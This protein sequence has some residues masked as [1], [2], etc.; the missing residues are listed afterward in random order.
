MELTRDQLLEIR[1]TLKARVLDGLAREGTEIACLPTYLPLPDGPQR[2][3]ALVMDAGGTNMR[4]SV[5]TLADGGNRVEAGPLGD[6][7]PTGRDG[8]PVAGDRFFEA[9]A[10][11]F[12]Q[13]GPKG[14]CPLGYCFSYPA[15][16][17]ASRDARLI[18]WT[19]GVDV[20]GVEGTLVGSR[21][22]KAL[23]KLSIPTNGVTVLNDTVASLLG[24]VLFERKPEFADRFIGLI[25]GTGTNMAGVFSARA[26]TKVKEWSGNMLVNLESGNFHPPHLQAFDDDY[27]RESDNPGRQRFEKAV[28]GYYLPYLFDRLSPG[29]IDPARGSAQLVEL[30][31]QGKGE[32]ARLAG[33]LLGRSAD[34]VAAGLAALCEIYTPGPTAIL[35]EGSLLWGDPQFATRMEE[36]V[37][38][39]IS[40]GRSAQLVKQRENVNLFGAASAAL[41]PA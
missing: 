7:V 8:K 2:G 9:Q 11:L 37:N 25:V 26:L 36:R 29:T 17:L 41:L 28:S 24:G 35:G 21:L 3:E 18:R 27:D 13:L 40:S 1:D 12:Q 31:E 38:D 34:L 32:A 33:Q 14:G 6:R 4:A 30:R 10:E 22:A 15:E 20:A 19:K 23:E 16:V 5:V 39:L